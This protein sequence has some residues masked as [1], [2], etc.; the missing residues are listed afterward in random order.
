MVLSYS[1][2]L[3]DICYEYITAKPI[4]FSSNMNDVS[5]ITPHLYVCGK[6]AINDEILK[7]LGITL[8]INSAKELS[9]Y[10]PSSGEL[11]LTL[12]KIPVHDVREAYLY[13]Y[14]MVCII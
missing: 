7:Q 14:F 1:N 5:E 9:N 10:E 12:V 4:M 13:P 2:I 8:I 3:D 11:S 6:M